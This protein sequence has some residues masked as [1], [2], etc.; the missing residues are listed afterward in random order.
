MMNRD[1]NRKI[2]GFEVQVTVGDMQ[3][4]EYIE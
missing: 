2:L 4:E 1:A 3:K